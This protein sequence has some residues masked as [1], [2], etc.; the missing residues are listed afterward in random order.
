MA[1]M[2]LAAG[3]F[4]QHEAGN[5]DVACVAG[6]RP[7]AVCL[8]FSGLKGV[9][10]LLPADLWRAAHFLYR[11]HFLPVPS[12]FTEKAY[13]ACIGALYRLFN[14]LPVLQLSQLAL[15]QVNSSGQLLDQI[16]Q[17]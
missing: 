8:V 16:L 7:A 17:A 3:Q 13:Q 11:Q 10:T 14:F 12:L 6:W 4:L 1:V 2:A 15:Q 5:L 9:F